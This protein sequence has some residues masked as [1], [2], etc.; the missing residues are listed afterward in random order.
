MSETKEFVKNIRMVGDKEYKENIRVVKM[1]DSWNAPDVKEVKA[2][3]KEFVLWGEENGYYQELIDRYLG[4]P[5]NNRCINGISDLIF[6]H[7][8]ECTDE[9]G[10]ANKY[11]Q[12]LEM[13]RMLNSHELYRITKDF[14]QLGQGTAIVNWYPGKNKIKSI[15]HTPTECWRAAVANSKTGVIEKYYYHPEWSKYE[16]RDKLKA[17]PT[18]GNGG[19]KDLQE[20]YVF[21]R[22]VSGYYY[23]TP[24]DYHGCLPYCEQEEEVANYHINNIQNGMQPSMLI[25]FRNGVPPIETQREIERKIMAKFSGTENSG[26]AIIEFTDGAE[27]AAEITPIHLPDA[28]AQYQFLSTEAREKVMLGHGVVS[29]I[30]LG[31]KDNTG[32]GNNAEELR[33]SSI[34]MDNMVVRP[35]QNILISGLKELFA[36]NKVFL[37]LYFKTLQ[38][39]EFTEVDKIAT[40]IRREEETGEKLS[41]IKM[42]FTDEEGDEMLDKL[43]G[44]GEKIDEDQWECIHTSVVDDPD[45]EF[46]LDSLITNMSEANP[47]QESSQDQGAYKVRYAYMPVRKSPDSRKFCKHMESYTDDKIVFRKEDINMMSFRGVNRPLGHKNRNYSLFRFKGGVNC[48][49]FWELRVYKSKVAPKHRASESSIAPVENPKEVPIRPIDM[50]NRGAYPTV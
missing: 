33:T 30:L 22:Y 9:L 12:R 4:S 5:T 31:I 20:I 49:H 43:S 13:K 48:H 35:F 17:M 27:Y 18:F 23:Y 26:K 42:D 25:S 16:K 34:L 15:V 24:A 1:S 50:P 8:L 28:H 45:E 29:P 39:I 46:D 10:I 11:M 37:N 2:D 44:L 38:P 32:F 6:G 47:N 36:V 3:G 7:G 21:R 14:K 40:K 19:D 41:D